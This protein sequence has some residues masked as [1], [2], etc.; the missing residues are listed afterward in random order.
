[1]TDI[2]YSIII[3]IY[4]VERYINQCIDSIINQTY[5]NI[6]IILVDDGSKDNCPQ[7]CDEY[8]KK[9][10]RV[11][12]IHKIN[13]GLVSAR[14]AGMA[15]ATGDYVCCVDG[16]D[17]ISETYIE[18]FNEIVSKY[19]APSI[20][21]C[22]YY[23]ATDEKYTP[24]KVNARAGYFN[25]LDI[26]KEI[27]PYLIQGEKGDYF[28]PTVWAKAIKI[29]L[30]KKHQ[31]KVSDDI[32]MGEDGACTIPC[33]IDATDM[34]ISDS[35]QYYYRTNRQSM[36]KSKKTLQW[37]GQIEIANHFLK[38]IS[39]EEYDFSEQID[40]RIEK[41]FFTVARTKYYSNKGYNEIKKDIM[42]G[43]QEEVFANAINKAKYRGAK[44]QIMDFIIKH[45]L[46]R[47][48]KLL[49]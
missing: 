33:I 26:K 29:D 46:L 3:P 16:D 21:C 20:I 43:Y 42:E 39:N 35:C 22:G 4:G 48:L 49:S 41:G 30:Y 38:Y 8:T 12:V 36:T 24:Q 9:D 10:N 37:K 34:F 19:N 11:R 44:M 6:E 47:A 31:C 17:Y 2:K 25:K 40:R 23:I 27:F 5:K 28:L 13:G 45:K 18:E 14:K 15:I 32:T 7:I 1:M